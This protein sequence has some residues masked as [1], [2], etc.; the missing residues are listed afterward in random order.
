LWPLDVRREWFILRVR[1]AEHV[2]G[3]VGEGALGV[4][5]TNGANY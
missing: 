4:G 2:V 3:K 1:L 5:G